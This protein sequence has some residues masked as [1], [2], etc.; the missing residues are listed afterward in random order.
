MAIRL[1]LPASG[2]GARHE[3]PLCARSLVIIGANGSGKSRFASF[4]AHDLGTR[5]FRV[6][7]LDALYQQG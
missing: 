5:G 3:I 6:S 1:K 7:A 4:M 2:D